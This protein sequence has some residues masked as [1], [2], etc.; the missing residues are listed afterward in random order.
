MTEIQLVNDD[1]AEVNVSAVEV[2]GGRLPVGRRAPALAA[3]QQAIGR[4]H[5]EAGELRL[6]G[7]YESLSM[8]GQDL[9]AVI[10]DL[11]TLHRDVK[12]YVAEIVDA[13][14]RAARARD[15]EARAEAGK[16]PLAK[17]DPDRSLG[18][19][20]VEVEGVGAVEVN[21][22]WDR[23]NWQSEKLLRE[24]LRRFFASYRLLDAD[25]TV[26]D[27]DEAADALH[28]WLVEVMPVTPSMQWRVGKADGSNG[29]RAFQINDEDYCDRTEKPRLARWPKGDR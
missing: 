23:K 24:I 28:A 13:H 6:A 22:G 12:L 8:G 9:E 26:I 2:W 4:M 3:I 29:L 10:D 17:N 14:E 5:A 18:S 11:H 21:G 25:G 16:K 20:R 15:A 27:N 1:P 7:D 19:V